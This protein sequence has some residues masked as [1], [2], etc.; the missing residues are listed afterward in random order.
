MHISRWQSARPEAYSVATG[1]GGRAT[2]LYFAAG[3]GG[4]FGVVSL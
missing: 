1:S 2:I 3:A 4:G